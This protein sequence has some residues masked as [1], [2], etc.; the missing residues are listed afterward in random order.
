MADRPVEVEKPDAF[1]QVCHRIGRAS[2]GLL[3]RTCALVV[4][5][6]FGDAGKRVEAHDAPDMIKR[7][8]DG[9]EIGPGHQSGA[10]IDAAFDNVTVH[11][12][13][14]AE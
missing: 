14:I 12:E 7:F 10:Q 13:Y 2:A 9:A 1:R 5:F 11:A 6:D 4:L 3:G 8:M